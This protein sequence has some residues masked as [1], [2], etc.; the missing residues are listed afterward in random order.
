[1]NS[2]YVVGA[3]AGDPG[4][5]TRRALRILREV[6]LVVA[7]DASGR[8]PIGRAQRLMTYLD[9]TTPLATSG[10]EAPLAALEK[11]DVA[12]LCP[13]WL[14]GLPAA[15]SR[16][17]RAAIERGH[18]VVSIPGPALPIT[19]LVISGLPADSFVYLGELPRH[20]P[21]RRELLAS[22]AG[23]R[24]TLLVVEQPDHLV[25]MLADLQASLGD[26]PVVIVAVRGVAGFASEAE[27][28][29]EGGAHVIWRGS[30]G[31]VP[32][33]LGKELVPG[34]EAMVER[35]LGVHEGQPELWDRPLPLVLIVGG[36][37]EPASS[38]SSTRG[39]WDESRLRTEIWA[40]REQ[41][42]GAREIVRLLTGESGWPR[43]EIYRLAVEEHSEGSPSSMTRSRM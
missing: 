35:D 17:V 11:G 41:G 36:A 1:V 9:I 21:A 42:L 43:R 37:R 23:E 16:L 13:D 22:V 24:R 14:L 26:R 12:Y 29:R 19:A 28:V 5:L 40:C 34:R 27:L 10:G 33:D 6:T 25:P 2:L 30:L 20:D 8:Q 31:Q 32:G 4:D 3:A 38:P 7:D 18:L 39:R 15:G